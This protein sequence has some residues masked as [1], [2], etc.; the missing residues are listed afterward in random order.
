MRRA[1]RQNK[2]EF[3]AI[4][5]TADGVPSWGRL[6]RLRKLV[7]FTIDTLGVLRSR[8]CWPSRFVRHYWFARDGGTA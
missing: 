6:L 4:S 3:A 1:I 2:A 7:A 5:G 8:E